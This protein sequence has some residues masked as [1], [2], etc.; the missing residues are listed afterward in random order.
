[1][2]Y[3]N[4]EA[5]V[6]DFKPCPFCGKTGTT[7]ITTVQDLEECKN[8]EDTEKCPCYED[9]EE[10]KDRCPYKTVV[11]CFYKGGCGATC[12]YYPTIEKAVAAWNTRR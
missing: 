6:F 8:F 1:M 2:T 10:D 5:F 9:F 3:C 4:S 11:C 7:E 12:G